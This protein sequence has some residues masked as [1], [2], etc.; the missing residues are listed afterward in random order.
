[1]ITVSLCGNPNVGKTVLFNAITGGKQH[2]GNFPGVTVQKIEGFTH[3]KGQKIK[4]VD[5][6]GIYGFG[7]KSP[8]EK[9]PRD[10]L[11]DE[12]PDVVVNIVNAANLERNLFLTLQLIEMGKNIILVVNMMDEAKNSGMEVNL[13]VLSRR[14]GIPVV[15]MVATRGEG[16]DELREKIIQYHDKFTRKHNL[17]LRY[18]E[19]IETLISEISEK[20]SALGLDDYYSVRWLSIMLLEDDED[21]INRVNEIIGKEKFENILQPIID[22]RGNLEQLK[23]SIVSEKYDDVSH[24]VTQAVHCED[25]EVWAFTDLLDHVF[26]HDILGWFIFIFLMWLGF[27]FT[28]DFGE[29]FSIM[30]DKGVDLLAVYSK[31]FFS[32]VFLKKL[33]ADGIIRGV[34]SVLVFLPNIFLLF[35]FLGLLEDSGYLSRAAF[36]A[37]KLMS[38]FGVT[39]RSLIP[40]LFGFGC[41]VPAIMSTR[42]IS[43]PGE[44]FVAIMVNP[45]VSCSARFAVYI[46]LCKIFFKENAAFALSM[47]YTA[48]IVFIMMLMI[49]FKKIILKGQDS[50]FLLEMPPYRKPMLK[51]AAIYAWMNGKHFLTKAF[52]IILISSIIIWLLTNFPMNVGLEGSYLVRVSKFISPVFAPL[53][54]GWHGTM[55]I[56]SGFAAKEVVISTFEMLASSTGLE[57]NGFLKTIFDVP[58]AV[59]FIMFIM[60]YVPCVATIYA[61]KYEV[62]KWRTAMLNV[63]FSTIVA[64]SVALL[65]KYAL[66]ATKGLW[67]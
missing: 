35:L 19:D 54:F 44:R 56:L 51:N 55:A 64:Y 48:N 57:I 29:P 38:R 59:A 9:V 67:S 50:M 8:D 36:V 65:F 6:P 39:G 18:G 52:T 26:T 10:Y 46:F 12:D 53:G 45:F 5:L 49:F 27:R 25:E 17:L 43:S 40:I 31:S 22:R 4:F 14:L 30:I 23:L 13:K 37:D 63:L 62:G 42:T 11:I 58:T 16:V 34:G 24:V 32:S 28:F 7:S 15:G 1:M 47:I 2:V 61:I 20:A 66:I 3:F 60:L 33:I 41:N 21:I